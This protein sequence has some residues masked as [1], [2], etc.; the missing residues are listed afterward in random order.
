M[1]REIAPSIPQKAVGRPP[2]AVLAVCSTS[3]CVSVPGQAISSVAF[4]PGVEVVV[5][6]ETVI[7]IWDENGDVACRKMSL[8]ERT[9]CMVPEA[10]FHHFLRISLRDHDRTIPSVSFG[11]G[12]D[13]GAVVWWYLKSWI[14]NNRAR[15]PKWCRLS[16]YVAAKLGVW[17]LFW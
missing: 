14:E 13:V 9:T 5:V 11:A 1:G 16:A 10:I 6:V 12:G 8:G 15:C 2:K 3:I 4:G 17:P 7:V